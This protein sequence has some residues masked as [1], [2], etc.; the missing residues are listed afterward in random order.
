M[1]SELEYA[2]K[3]LLSHFL[4]VFWPIFGSSAG[5]FFLLV[6][7]QRNCNESFMCAS[8]S[9][10][11]KKLLMNRK[12]LFVVDFEGFSL[13]SS[14]TCI[15]FRLRFPFVLVLLLLSR[16]IPVVVSNYALREI[17]F[18]NRRGRKFPVFNKYRGRCLTL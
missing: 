6:N 11:C 4:C 2:C 1:C 7:I 15:N 9:T 13:I 14:H 3:S 10:S 8:M 17:F 18:F 12:Q 5:L 16:T